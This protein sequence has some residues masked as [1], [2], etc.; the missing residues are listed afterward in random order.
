MNT[1][2]VL[3]LQFVCTNKMLLFVIIALQENVKI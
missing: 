1:N 3:F 2:Q